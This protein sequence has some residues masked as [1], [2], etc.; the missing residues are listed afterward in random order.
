M[1]VRVMS[2][3]LFVCCLRRLATHRR[4]LQ[5]KASAG[6]DWRKKSVCLGQSADMPKTG[7]GCSFSVEN[8]YKLT[9]ALLYLLGLG[10]RH[11]R[12]SVYPMDP[13]SASKISVGKSCCIYL[14]YSF[15]INFSKLSCLVACLYSMLPKKIEG[16]DMVFD[17][18]WTAT[19]VLQMLWFPL[20]LIFCNE[21]VW[22]VNAVLS[23]WVQSFIISTNVKTS[24]IILLLF[25]SVSVFC[26]PIIFVFTYFESDYYYSTLSSILLGCTATF[27]G[28]T[29]IT[30]SLYL[31]L[32]ESVC[33]GVMNTCLDFFKGLENPGNRSSINRNSISVNHEDTKKIFYIP[34]STSLET[35][36]S[37]DSLENQFIRAEHK[38]S[39]VYQIT[40]EFASLFGFAI[41]MWTM[42]SLPN[43]TLCLYFN[44]LNIRKGVFSLV[45]SIIQLAVLSS[46]LMFGFSV[47]SIGDAFEKMVR[48]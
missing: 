42:F 47:F 13:E 14:F 22:N 2:R 12:S 17:R 31:A 20:T 26:V 1:G 3:H 38:I 33:I 45:G 32:F 37:C 15:V 18:I 41:L 40:E 27:D 10:T 29:G 6:R 4:A 30:F 34:E 21:Q 11:E 36:G 46:Q 39:E 25:Y 9:S 43:Y 35:N 44:L 23:R 7:R 24:K 48:I 28:I 8:L 19:Y 5:S 16:K